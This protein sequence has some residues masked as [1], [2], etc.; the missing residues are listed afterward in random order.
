MNRT[1]NKT[2]QPARTCGTCSNTIRL[3]RYPDTVAC[4]V[5]LESRHIHN[6]TECVHYLARPAAPHP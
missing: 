1:Q 5:M 2:E 4:T 6:L 3:K